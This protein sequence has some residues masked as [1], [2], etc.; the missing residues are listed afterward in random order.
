MDRGFASQYLQLA[1][2]RYVENVESLLFLPVGSTSLD[3]AAL[4]ANCG[5]YAMGAEAT[6]ATKKYGSMV[7]HRPDIRCNRPASRLRK[8]R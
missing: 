3:R 2:A 6:E 1:E 5:S 7:S 4:A 8:S